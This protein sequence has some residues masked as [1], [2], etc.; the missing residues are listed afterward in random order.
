VSNVLSLGDNVLYIGDNVESDMRDPRR[1]GWRT[2]VILSELKRDVAVNNPDE[3][4]VSLARLLEAKCFLSNVYAMRRS[5]HKYVKDATRALLQDEMDQVSA[6]I[7]SL[8][9][10]GFGS[11]LSCDTQS[12]FF[13]LRVFRHCDLLT[14]RVSN[15]MNYGLDA[16]LTPRST[17][18]ALPH[19]VRT[20]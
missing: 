12:S 18:K 2:A 3:Y 14:S 19:E 16:Y 6:R 9:E 11:S 15:F 17:T 5:S 1:Y 10:S 13:G 8:S 7:R 4:R 20:M